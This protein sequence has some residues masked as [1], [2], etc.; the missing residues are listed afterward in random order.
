MIL[1]LDQ[2]LELRKGRRLVFT[3]GVF[4][5]LHAG[6]VT[7]LRHARSLGDLLIVGINTDESVRRL[8]KGAERPWTTLEDRATVLA[9]LRDVDG[10]VAFQNDTPCALIDALKPEVHV[11]GGDY[12]ADS[13]PEYPNVA[14]YGGRVE[15]VP[16]V[17]GRSTSKLLRRLGLE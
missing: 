8:A 10:V 16:L 12:Q 1:T 3:N 15:I 9:A 13:L 5:L 14:A 6:H 17:E 7:L 11:K 2:A 4:D